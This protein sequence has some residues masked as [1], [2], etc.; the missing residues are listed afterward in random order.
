MIV[1]LSKN[2]SATLKSVYNCLKRQTGIQYLNSCLFRCLRNPQRVTHSI[3]TDVTF[4]YKHN[5]EFTPFPHERIT[6][7]YDDYGVQICHR[8]R[9]FRC[10]HVHQACSSP[11][12]Y[13]LYSNHWFN[14]AD[15]SQLNTRQDNRM[16]RGYGGDA[17]L[18][19]VR[20][21]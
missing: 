9:Y 21:F 5:I 15:E 7:F 13:R 18:V 16:Q 1:C 19:C 20:L 3:V 6:R 10:R 4:N 14:P 17:R 12:R 8:D 2:S 11:Y